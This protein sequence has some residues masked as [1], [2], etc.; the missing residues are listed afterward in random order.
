M[1]LAKA[2]RYIVDFDHPVAGEIKVLAVPIELS[3]T[4]GIVG[5]T[6]PELGQ[7]SEEILLELGECT[8]QEISELKEAGVII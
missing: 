2:L 3:E 4:P 5:K 6:A 7:H 8:W 1:Q